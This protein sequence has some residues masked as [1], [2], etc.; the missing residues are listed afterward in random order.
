MIPVVKEKI[1]SVFAFL[2]N[3][4]AKSVYIKEKVCKEAVSWS[5][6]PPLPMSRG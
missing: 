6:L 5:I 4:A 2:I 3:T 1:K